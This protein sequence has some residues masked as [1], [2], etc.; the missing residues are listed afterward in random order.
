MNITD[1]YVKKLIAGSYDA[2]TALYHIYAPQLYAYIF[3]LM[4]SK[5]IT[6]DIVQETFI[7]IWVKRA[8]I[9]EDLS[10][11]SFIFTIAKNKLLNEFRRQLKNPVFSDYM[12]LQLAE[13][14]PEESR[15]EQQID[16]DEFNRQLQLSKK[17]ITPRQVQ[18]FELNKEQGLSIEEIAVKLNIKEQVVRNQLS[19]ALRTLR[20][21][22]GRFMLL[23]TI[24]F[25]GRN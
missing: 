10:F 19:L 15:I 20:G 6:N 14:I 12:S 25:M 22:M 8:E 4:K 1:Q 18:I 5:S 21:E 7:I 23:F 24:F 17:K 11:K 2:F 13:E 3:G 16:F 9:R